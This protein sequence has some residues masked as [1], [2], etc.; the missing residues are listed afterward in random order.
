MIDD[1]ETS[2]TTKD[3]IDK[4]SA[5]ADDYNTSNNAGSLPDPRHN[6]IML[7]TITNIPVYRDLTEKQDNNVRNFVL[8]NSITGKASEIIKSQQHSLVG[9]ALRGT[10]SIMDACTFIHIE[11]ICIPVSVELKRKDSIDDVQIVQAHPER[12]PPPSGKSGFPDG[13]A[14]SVVDTSSYCAT[15]P[16]GLGGNSIG[17]VWA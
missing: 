3:F 16:M 13:E 4:E 11:C 5:R 17:N 14:I 10:L 8:I 2:T 15:G 6:S 1:F 9:L 7:T 12:P